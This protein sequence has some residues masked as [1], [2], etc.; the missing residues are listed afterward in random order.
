M[1]HHRF[2]RMIFFSPVGATRGQSYLPDPLIWL[3]KF[4]C[5]VVHAAPDWKQATNNSKR[6]RSDQSAADKKERLIR[7]PAGHPTEPVAPFSGTDQW[8]VK[9]FF[10]PCL[11][12]DPRQARARCSI[13]RRNQGS[14]KTR[15]INRRR[16][17]ISGGSGETVAWE[18]VE[19]SG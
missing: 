19:V 16:A 8:Y 10:F 17:M 11:P 2:K 4:P 14:R 18:P 13:D 7:A 6:D 5:S 15:A 1:S 3:S 9:W 12:I